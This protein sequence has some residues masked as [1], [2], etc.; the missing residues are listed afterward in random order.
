MRKRVNRKLLLEKLSML[1]YDAAID[2]ILKVCDSQSGDMIADS[3]AKVWGY[4]RKFRSRKKEHF[5][6]VY[7]NNRN[8]VLG[9]DVVSVG[10]ISEAIVHPR[11]IFRS[12]IVALASGIIL[13]H[14]HP[15]GT[16]TP[17]AEDIAVTKR[18][19]EAGRIVGI[20][21]IDHVVMSSRSYLSM[22]EGEYF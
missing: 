7:V 22:R 18:I 21:L 13:A 11:E 14:N 3:P 19:E 9:F 17:S 8:L 20:K 10:T 1:D 16:V 4:L 2:E 15:S 6:A 5:I 12:A